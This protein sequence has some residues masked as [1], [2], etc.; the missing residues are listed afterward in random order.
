MSIQEYKHK[1]KPF[2]H[3]SDVLLLS[4]DSVY[5]AY[6][7]EPG[8]GKSKLLLD[9]A[10]YLYEKGEIEALVISTVK[11]VCPTFEFIEVP[12]HV[13]ERIDRAIFR[14]DAA[15]VNNKEFKKAWEAFLKFDG[16]KIFIFNVEGAFSKNL[17]DMMRDLYKIIGNRY[18]MGIDESTTIK[19][20]TAKRSKA[21]IKFSRAA[22]YRR[23]LTG[24][25]ITNGPLEVFGQAMALAPPEKILG[26]KSFYSFRNYYANMEKK[27]FGNRSFQVVTGYK[28]TEELTELMSTFSSIIKKEDALDLPEKIYS[29]VIVEMTKTQKAMYEKLKQEA[30][31]E[32]EEQGEMVEVTNILT[33]LVKLHQIVCGQLK[34]EDENG[35]QKYASIEN[36]R[37]STLMELL[38]LERGKV[39]IWANYRQSLRDVSK[40]I[41]DEYGKN[42][43]IE[44]HGGVGPNEKEVAAKRFQ[45]PEDPCRFFVANPQSAGMGL[46]LTQ[47]DLAIYYSNDYSLGSRIQSEDRIHRISQVNHARY[48]DLV[49]PD[50]VD[51]KIIKALTSKKNFANKVVLSNWRN[52]L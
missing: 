1:T 16:F 23:I 5:W 10:A 24:T 4:A 31:I 32:L 48:I 15:K 17:T 45:D 51:E 13:P 9:N 50:T 19:T 38:S 40:A 44:Y 22:K 36:N 7:L 14:Y 25:P 20:H 35:N 12:T 34:Y 2:K 30:I 21:I 42:S 41:S 27:T 11:A 37:I 29:K 52:I 18:M 3:Q 6:F 26:H 49:S 39:V 28:N 8:L 46:T 43:V 47:S 33:M